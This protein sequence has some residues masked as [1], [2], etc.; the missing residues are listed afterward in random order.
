MHIGNDGMSVH[1]QLGLG[2]GRLVTTEQ[3]WTEHTLK[4]KRILLSSEFQAAIVS[5][6]FLA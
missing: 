3:E 6:S 1:G 2:R 4:T 5:L